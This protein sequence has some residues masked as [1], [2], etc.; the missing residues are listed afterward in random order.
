MTEIAFDDKVQLVPR[1]WATRAMAIV[2]RLGASETA[3]RGDPSLLDGL[4]LGRERSRGMGGLA[5]VVC[6]AA[7]HIS[8]DAS[9]VS[10]MTSSPVIVVLVFITLNLFIFLQPLSGQFGTA[11]KLECYM[12]CSGKN[13]VLSPRSRNRRTSHNI[14]N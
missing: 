12:D 10:S 9:L 6:L 3:L 8:T 1:Y 13:T 14:S 5:L 7:L 4:E 2:A 11:T